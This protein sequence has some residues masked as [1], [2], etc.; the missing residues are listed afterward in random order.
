MS[1]SRFNLETSASNMQ[2]LYNFLNINKAGTFLDDVTIELSQ[3]DTKLTI[4]T[5][6]AT[7]EINTG[8]IAGTDNIATFT[9]NVTSSLAARAGVSSSYSV[10]IKGAILC[11]N[12]LIF[13]ISSDYKGHSP[14]IA[15]TVDNAG[16][17]AVIFKDS[18]SFLS[19]GSSADINAISGYRVTD[20]NSSSRATVTLT[21]QYG[22]QK[23]SL[24]P[25]VP[26]C[27]DNS[28]LLPYAYAALHTQASGIGIQAMRMNGSNYITNGVWYIKDGE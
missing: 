2:P 21:P 16:E 5:A 15:V 10:R 17:L 25:I 6:N 18:S 19:G 23:T 11:N 14:E 4:S 28:I 7:F 24:A 12:G 8:S 1:I 3:E 9:A 13:D 20:T 27:N 26:M 22:A